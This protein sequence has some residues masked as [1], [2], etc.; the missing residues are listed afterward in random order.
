MFCFVWVEIFECDIERITATLFGRSVCWKT[1]EVS[2]TKGNISHEIN[3]LVALHNAVIAVGRS[4]EI[5]VCPAFN[6]H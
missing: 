1:G 5:L 3:L 6:P 2:A 4:S